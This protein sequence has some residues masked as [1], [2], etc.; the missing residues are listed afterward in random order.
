VDKL[1]RVVLTMSDSSVLVIEELGADI[2]QVIER[3]ADRLHQSV[4]RQLSRIVGIDRHGIRPVWRLDC[5]ER[6]LLIGRTNLLSHT[7]KR[8]ET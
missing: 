5:P 2:D 1:C 4:A 8:R 6:A 3:V 7:S